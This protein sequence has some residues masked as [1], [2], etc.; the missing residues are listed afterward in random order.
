[1][2]R[3][4]AV[5]PVMVGFLSGS[6]AAAKTDWYLLDFESGNCIR[7]ASADTQAASPALFEKYL[8][9]HEVPV[10]DEIIRNE[11]RSVKA[12]KVIYTYKG[13]ERALWYMSGRPICEYLKVG[14]QKQGLLL[15]NPDLQ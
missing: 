15:D 12:V 8:R 10:R 1:M 9:E 7:A 13:E 3:F 14:M 6:P 5:L 11:D 2:V 4:G